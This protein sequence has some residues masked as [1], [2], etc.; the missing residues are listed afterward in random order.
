VAVF[1]SIVVTAMAEGERCG[2]D[3]SGAAGTGEEEGR[4][5]VGA[6]GRGGGA[7]FPVRDGRINQ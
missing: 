2:R 4:G 3:G 6:V 5:G 1:K 7:N